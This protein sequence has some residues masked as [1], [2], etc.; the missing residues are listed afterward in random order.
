[1]SEWIGNRAGE[2]VSVLME[3]VKY[4]EYE[5]KK[6]NLILDSY[7]ISREDKMLYLTR[8]YS[9]SE[10]IQVLY[11]KNRASNIDA[12]LKVIKKESDDE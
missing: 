5:I 4:L 7:D 1:M 12:H 8:E 10:R 6:A 11:E 3:R 9:V 2:A